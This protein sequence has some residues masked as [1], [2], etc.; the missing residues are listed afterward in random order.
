MTLYIFFVFF[1]R[2][3]SFRSEFTHLGEIRSIVPESINLMALTAT[4]TLCTRSFIIRS[5]SMINPAVVYIPPVKDNI[6]YFVA[7]KDTIE[8]YF[9]PFVEKMR[10]RTIRRSIIFCRTY[11]DI[12][13]LHQYFVTNL[14]DYATEPQGAPNYVKFRVIDIFTHCTHPTVKQKVLEQFTMPSSPLQVVIATI[15][16]GMGIN[17]PNIRQVIHW[18]APEDPEMYLQESGRAGR[19]GGPAQAILVRHTHDSKF[20]SKQMLEYIKN[21]SQCRR[22]MFLRDFPGCTEVSGKSC[23]CCDVCA[24]LCTCDQCIKK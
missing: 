21:T 3:D 11:G 8:Q 19:D 10:N 24:S 12:I 9:K 18:G 4:A 6:T 14:G 13:N 2:G 15:A 5:L 17:C 20:A 1:F 7:E 22:S 16:F 23:M